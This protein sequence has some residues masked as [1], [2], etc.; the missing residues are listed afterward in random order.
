MKKE[1]KQ[2]QREEE[3]RRLIVLKS[4]AEKEAAGL[5]VQNIRKKSTWKV[6]RCMSGKLSSVEARAANSTLRLM[7]R[8]SHMA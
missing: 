2:I 8:Y 1:C 5:F 6:G 4:R 3:C 7:S